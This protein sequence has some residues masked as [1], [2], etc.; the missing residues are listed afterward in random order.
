MLSKLSKYMHEQRGL[1]SLLGFLITWQNVEAA[2]SAC[3]AH[4]SANEIWMASQAMMPLM[5]SI[6][7]HYSE[8]LFSKVFG[9]R[10]HV[11]LEHLR[12]SLRKSF[13]DALPLL[14]WPIRQAPF[15]PQSMDSLQVFLETFI[16]LTKTEIRFDVC[17]IQIAIHKRDVSSDMCHFLL[18][19]VCCSIFSKFDRS[20]VEHGSRH[21]MAL[22]LLV[23]PLIV[24]F[25]FHFQTKRQTNRIDKVNTHLPF[26][27]CHC[28]LASVSSQ[29]FHIHPTWFDAAWMVLHPC[30]EER[31]WA[32]PFHW[33]THS[34]DNRWTGH[35]HGRR[36]ARFLLF[37]LLLFF[38]LQG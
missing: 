24:R 7:S 5:D 9:S 23:E 3:E 33:W 16:R 28:S 29:S 14:S 36:C 35:R 21:L 30:P 25:K 26:L 19:I 1:Q 6:S 31:K 20:S 8:A 2:L 37:F 32:Y 18:S 12:G 27:T 17:Q 13:A 10:I 11:I 34:A 15:S 38:V 4:L 22:Q